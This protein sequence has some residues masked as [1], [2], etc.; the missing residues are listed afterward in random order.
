MKSFLL[1]SLLFI[2]QLN[3][4]TPPA[5]PPAN[6]QGPPANAGPAV[7]TPTNP[8]TPVTPQQPAG[9]TPQQPPLTPQYGAPY[10]PYNP[11]GM[12]FNPAF[13]DPQNLKCEFG[14]CLNRRITMSPGQGFK[15]Y[16]QQPGQ[17]NG[18]DLTLNVAFE[19]QNFGSHVSDISD[20]VFDAPSRNTKITINSMAG[21]NVEIDNLHCKKPGACTNLDL[22]CGFGVECWNMN[23]H[24]EIGACQGCTVN[25]QSCLMLSMMNGNN[26]GYY[27]MGY[28]YS[29][30]PNTFGA[31]GQAAPGGAAPAMPQQ[32]VPQYP[33]YQQ[34]QFNPYQQWI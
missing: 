7:V 14:A 3:G 11:Y 2:G 4:Q 16:C 32:G 9:V 28:G 24:C 19:P 20:L 15:L 13:A 8:A 18:L 10:N 29:N 26:G 22:K 21:Q 34:P 31:P 33:Q 5:A 6:A 30:T 23:V 1:S 25:G 27:G 17:C 12:G